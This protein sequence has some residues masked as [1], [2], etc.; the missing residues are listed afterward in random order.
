MLTRYTPPWVSRDARL[1]IATRALRTFGY[2]CTSVLLAAMLTQDGDSPAQVGVLLA[3]AAIGSVLASLLMGIFADRFG[4]RNSLL[5]TSALMAA[6]GVA[7]AVCESYPLLLV[8]AFIGTISP[9]TNDNTPFSGVEQA[10]LA[11]T[12]PNERHTSLFAAYNMTA[13]A[14]GALGG[15]AAAGLGLIPRVDPGDAAFAVYAGI[16][17]VIGA[18][19]LR[20]SSEAE[21]PPAATGL[22]ARAADNRAD[23]R[24]YREVATA[25]TP[26][27]PRS[28]IRLAS[29]FALDAFAGGLAVQAIL[30]LW[31]Q[32]RYGVSISELGLLFFATN[33]LP[34]LSQALAPM[35]AARRGLLS[36]MVVPHFVSNILLVCIPFAP[37]FG[38]AAALLLV[39]QTLSKIDVPAR[40]AFTAGIVGPEHRTAAASLTSVARSV[41][42]S[43]SPLTS[44]LLLTGSL[45]AVGAPLLVGGSLA[46][47]YDISMWQSFRDL[48]IA[49]QVATRLR[50]RHRRGRTTSSG[51]G[52]SPD[53]I[54]RSLLVQTGSEPTGPHRPIRLLQPLARERAQTYTISQ[55]TGLAHKRIGTIGA[56]PCRLEPTI[57]NSRDH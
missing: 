25:P 16:A 4:R 13:L 2:G 55:T 49:K 33:L 32:Q 39:R 6:A 9:S 44:S 31:F 47:V 53:E 11:Q 27:M 1:V 40:Q 36:T 14:G 50:G 8:A 45:M 34:A 26:R 15:L 41:A 30:A 7:F 23:V 18:L 54:A 12:C 20:L 52:R 35:L 3:V 17:V 42:V 22:S 46:V 57:A 19:F 43:A 10:I 51:T 24:E 21:A 38:A 37:T 48:P 56:Q 29:L 28:V 5:L